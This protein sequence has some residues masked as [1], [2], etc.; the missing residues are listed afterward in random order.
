MLSYLASILYCC[1]SAAVAA[2]IRRVSIFLLHR[3]LEF[4]WRFLL[5]F[6][7]TPELTSKCAISPRF[8]TGV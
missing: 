5:R 4:I 7:I 2:A 8:I 6:R 3:K 1:V